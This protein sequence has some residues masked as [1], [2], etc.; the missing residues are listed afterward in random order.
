MRAQLQ[1]D[2]AVINHSAVHAEEAL[3]H[4]HHWHE[5]KQ[6]ATTGDN[7]HF[8]AFEIGQRHGEAPA[9]EAAGKDA[10]AQ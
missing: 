2:V 7:P 5:A 9:V 1:S 10:Y 3:Q 6:H 4:R 8:D